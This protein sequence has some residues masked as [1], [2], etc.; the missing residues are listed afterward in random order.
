MEL[1]YGR[2]EVWS[3]EVILLVY[4]VRVT[5]VVTV[6]SPSR[7]LSAEVIKAAEYTYYITHIQMLLAKTLERIFYQEL[8]KSW[9]FIPFKNDMAWL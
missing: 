6:L 5:G 3:S 1:V 9:D 8:W 7:I 4:E 2:V